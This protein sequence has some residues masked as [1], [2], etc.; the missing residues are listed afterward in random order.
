[1]KILDLKKNIEFVLSRIKAAAVKS[2]RKPADVQ[3]LAVSKTVSS[4]LIAQAAFLGLTFFGESRVDEAEVKI[5]QFPNLQWHLVG[6]LQRR[7][8]KK[9][10][11]LFQLIH[12]V[13]SLKLIEKIDQEA[14]NQGV[15]HVAVLLELNISGEISKYGFS[16][17]LFWEVL[18][19]LE[20]YRHVRVRGLMTM[21]P[22]CDEPE[23]SRPIFRRLREIQERVLREQV[24]NVEMGILSMGMSH[25]FEVAVEE[26]ATLVRVGSRLFKGADSK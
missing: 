7:K 14:Q 6:H 1:M 20:K 17:A 16:E 3:L 11:P 13:D 5:R 2:G 26:G 8:V 24:K 18:P 19:V 12:S 21:A 25:D 10:L 15:D 22:L 23:K 9:A 4:E